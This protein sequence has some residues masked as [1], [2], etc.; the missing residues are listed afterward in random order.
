MLG[1]ESVRELLDQTTWAFKN[2]LF[3]AFC[4][5]CDA[6]I[7]TEDNLYFS[8]LLEALLLRP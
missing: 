4:R 1:N 5:R 7:L 8:T 2:L 6:R 3:P